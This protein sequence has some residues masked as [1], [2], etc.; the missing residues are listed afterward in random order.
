MNLID[1]V[2]LAVVAGI[3]LL[4]TCYIRKEKKKGIQCIGCPDASRCAGKCSG[5]CG[6]Q[7]PKQ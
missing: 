3:V 6:C 7:K 5:C 2:I 4:V 1:G